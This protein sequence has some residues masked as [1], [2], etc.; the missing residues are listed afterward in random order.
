M[1]FEIVQTLVAGAFGAIFGSYATLFAHRLPSGQ[2]CFGRYFGPK[3][4][5]PDCKKI[6]R[7][8]ELIPL[9]NWLVTRGKCS[10]CGF[11]IPRSHLFLE[12]SIAILFMICYQ[13][14]GFS[15][16]FIL[17]ALILT[18]SMVGVVTDFKE[19]ILPDS[20]LFVILLIGLANRVLVDA[21]VIAVIFSSAV[22]VMAATIFYQVFYEDGKNS[23]ITKQDQA[24]AYGKFIVI[25]SVCLP[26]NSFVLYTACFL[27]TISI[28][29][30]SGKFS[31]K[32]SPRLGIA[33]IIPFVWLLI[34]PPLSY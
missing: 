28:F 16:D 1:I 23:L 12:G 32:K 18:A 20:I 19:N 15:D 4:H 31:K 22:G 26:I 17:M 2:S 7:T 5:C 24:F 10:D 34:Y 6:L 33:L 27:L 14:F 13:L 25:A 21:N 11:K 30:L 8:R 9:I 3:S 29:L